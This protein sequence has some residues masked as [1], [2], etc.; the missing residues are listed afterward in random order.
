M[1]RDISNF[2]IF[3]QQ[4]PHY[5]LLINH[6]HIYLLGFEELRGYGDNRKCRAVWSIQNRRNL[7]QILNKD[8]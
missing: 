5:N 8:Q 3:F 6:Q 2:K 1:I 4:T 7:I